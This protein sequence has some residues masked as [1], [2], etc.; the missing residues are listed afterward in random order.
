MQNS[1]TMKT[2]SQKAIDLSHT[3]EDGMV[4]YHGLP[5]PVIGDYQ[6]RT[7]SEHHYAPGTTFQIGRIEMIANTGTYIDAPSHR[8]EH[9]ADIAELSLC[10]VA[11]LQGVCVIV[12]GPGRAIEKNVFE[13]L[14]V[15][16]HAVLLYTGWAV[17]W[18]TEQVLPTIRPD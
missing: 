10:A 6:K 16:G 4:T 7:D 15:T 18:R 12:E 2:H 3:I 5:A 11:N 1:Q 14:D 13:G 8:Y 9:G 17:H